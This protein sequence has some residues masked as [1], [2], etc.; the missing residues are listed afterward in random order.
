VG[1]I[2]NEV[3]NR[4]FSAIFGVDVALMLNDDPNVI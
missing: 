1:G 3:I 4:E 2:G